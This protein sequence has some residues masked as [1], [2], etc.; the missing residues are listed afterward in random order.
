[1]NITFNKY[2]DNP[3]L[4]TSV[5][6]TR[7]IYRNL[8]KQKFD[9]LMVR[10]QGQLH[11][12]IFNTDDHLDT[13]YIHLKIPSEKIP[14]LYYDVVL[15]FWTD[16][17]NEKDSPT[18]RKYNVRFYS[19]DQ[20]FIFTFAHA[21]NSNGL[22]IDLLKTKMLKRT[23]TDKAKERNPKDDIWYVKSLCFAF[24]AMER[25][26]LFNRSML[27]QNGRKFNRSELLNGVQSAESKIEE[28]RLKE[29][30]L[31]DSYRAERLKARAQKELDNKKFARTNQLVKIAST[32][33]PVKTAK[34]IK[35]IKKK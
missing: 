17:P 15:E 14:D 26:L 3:S 8:Y 33:K 18:I 7:Q 16:D 12:K 20:A 5:Y 32:V 10:E 4:G 34:Q 1:V 35:K 19:N 29:E 13:H 9:N 22:F 27:N 30:Q 2:M 6:S 21:F 31:K 11:Y 25:Y 23:L 24:Y 28:R